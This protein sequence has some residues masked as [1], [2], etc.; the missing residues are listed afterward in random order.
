[1]VSETNTKLM[2]VSRNQ[3]FACPECDEQF[4]VTESTRDAVLQNGCPRCTAPV[5]AEHISEQ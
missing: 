4:P 3:T 1:M 2:A 5:S